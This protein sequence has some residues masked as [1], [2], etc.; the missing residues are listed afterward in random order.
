[1][2][3]YT[4]I[5]FIA[6]LLII[7]CGGTGEFEYESESE[8]NE[9][10]FGIQG[11]VVK[12]EGEGVL[13]TSTDRLISEEDESNTRY[14][15]AWL[16]GIRDQVEIGQRIEVAFDGGVNLSYPVQAMGTSVRLLEDEAPKGAELTRA[17]AVR[18]VLEMPDVAQMRVPSVLE[19]IYNE[20]DRNWSVQLVDNTAIGYTVLTVNIEDRTL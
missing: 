12:I 16:S 20:E 15:A 2:K 4:F 3:S 14:D 9:K 8:A 6:M 17:Q 10:F 5:I 7:G 19:V 13:V 1:M 11:T 18:K